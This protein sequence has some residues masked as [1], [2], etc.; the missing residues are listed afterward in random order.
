MI[1]NPALHESYHVCI[2]IPLE[3]LGIGRLH[4]SSGL[5]RWNVVRARGFGIGATGNRKL[6]E[7]LLCEL[8]ER[9]LRH[10]RL[11]VHCE[12]STNGSNTLFCNLELQIR[13]ESCET[14]NS[15]LHYFS[16]GITFGSG[17]E[18][19]FDALLLQRRQINHRRNTFGSVAG[20]GIHGHRCDVSDNER[21]SV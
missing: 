1:E 15:R 13:D 7:S 17:G 5:S 4:G 21:R 19:V 8:L 6:A 3:A 11:T 10:I 2:R 18:H 14:T 9:S 12:L 20:R 16:G